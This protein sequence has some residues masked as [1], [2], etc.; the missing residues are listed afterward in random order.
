M[1]DYK[2]TEF[3]SQTAQI[4]VCFKPL[5]IYIAIDLP[6]NEANEV[7][8]GVELDTYIKGFL[9]YSLLERNQRLVDGVSNSQEIIKLLEAD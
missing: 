1:T 7:P 5:N 8:T 4:V 2:I 6:L 3:N 9:P